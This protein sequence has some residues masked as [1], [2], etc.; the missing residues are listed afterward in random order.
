ME[1]GRRTSMS[2]PRAKGQDY[3]STSTLS[4]KKRRKIQSR[5]RHLRIC[6][7]GSTIPETKWEMETH[8]IFIQNNATS[9]KKLQNLRQGITSN[10]RSFIKVETISIR[11][12]GTL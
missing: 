8:S 7:R 3:K 11:Y 9:G 1:M 6:N 2:F 12:K 5:N 10:S 4:S